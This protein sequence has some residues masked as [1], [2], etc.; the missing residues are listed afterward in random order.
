MALIDDIKVSL[1]VTSTSLNEDIQNLIDSSIID[2]DL[3]GV[4]N[5]I[6]TSTTDANVIRA[7]TA[8]VGYHF[9]LTHGS[10]DRAKAFKTA[11]DEMKAQLGMSSTY[12]VWDEE[13]EE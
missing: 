6:S 5:D 9:H 11:Y 8:Y 13:E 4:D 1:Q 7:I 2:L 10:I 3:A 12:S